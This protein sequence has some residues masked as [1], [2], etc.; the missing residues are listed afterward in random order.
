MKKFLLSALSCALLT[1]MTACNSEEDMPAPVQGDHSSQIAATFPKGSVV[2][3]L[4]LNI[5]EKQRS[6]SG[7]GELDATLPLW[8]VFS[9]DEKEVYVR[10]GVY[11]S[12]GELYYTNEGKYASS[13]KTQNFQ[14]PVPVPKDGD[15]GVGEVFVWV[16]KIGNSD[17]YRIDW[18]KKTV[19]LNEQTTATA[20]MSRLGDAW[21]AKITDLTAEN[22]ILKR[23]FVQVNIISDELQIDGVAKLFESGCHTKLGLVKD[24]STEILGDDNGSLLKLPHTWHWDSDTFDFAPAVIPGCINR[25]EFFSNGSYKAEWLGEE[26]FTYFALMYLFAPSEEKG[27]VDQNGTKY[28]RIAFTFKPADKTSYEHNTNDWFLTPSLPDM[29]ANQRLLIV[30]GSES[31]DGNGFFTNHKYF[32]TT[33]DNLYDVDNDYQQNVYDI[34]HPLY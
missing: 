13:S 15:G 34:E 23:P 11:L 2:K 9:N 8:D 30:A 32:N 22:T 27:W 12:N 33:I 18:E 4:K 20:D 10:F 24:T 28:D 1:I 19:T 7:I 26:C 21:C 16:D 14:F 5:P 17:G 31:Y 6:R 3:E 29:K 25:N